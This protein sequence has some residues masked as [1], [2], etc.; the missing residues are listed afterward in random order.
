[1]SRIGKKTILVPQGVTV[2]VDGLLISIKGPKG[3]LK[4]TINH[5]MNVIVEGN[6]ITIL[7]KNETK[8]SPALW[9]LTRT[10]IANMVEGVSRGYEKHLEF[11]GVG[12]R[13]TA[14]ASSLGLQLGFSHPVKYPAPKG[15]TFAVQKNLITI[16]GI[17]KELVGEVA[18]QVRALKPPEPYKGKGIR[19]RGEVIRRK[20]GKKTVAS[21]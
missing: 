21:G 16:T 6:T 15:I 3:E 7:P 12:F 19:Y 17:D 2:A 14:D 13:A 8:Q 10:L 11:E 1:M 4:R 18:A 5:E 20:A 9:G